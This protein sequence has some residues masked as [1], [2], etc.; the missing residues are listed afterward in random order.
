MT[1]VIVSTRTVS[2]NASLTE[3]V[4][5]ALAAT[6]HKA[7]VYRDPYGVVLIIGPFNG[8]LTLLLRPAICP[9]D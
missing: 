1:D 3:P 6:G 8:P 7:F 5:K 4:P 9:S 2:F